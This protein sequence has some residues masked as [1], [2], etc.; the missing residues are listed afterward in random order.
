MARVTVAMLR[1]D[2]LAAIEQIA[3]LAGPGGLSASDAVALAKE[4]A[5]RQRGLEDLEDGLA[6]AITAEALIA[7][8]PG[9]RDWLMVNSGGRLEIDVPA[10]VE[11]TLRARERAGAAS[12]TERAPAANGNE[13]LFSFVFRCDLV[14]DIVA[15]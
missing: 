8:M 3:R 11:D 10:Y 4:I 6:E 14:Y 9:S 7:C 15:R 12:G 1:D 5:L 2:P 13:I